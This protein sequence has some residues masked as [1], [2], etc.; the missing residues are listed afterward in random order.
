MVKPE[1]C[2]NIV[3]CDQLLMERAFAAGLDKGKTDRREVIKYGVGA[4]YLLQCASL[5]NT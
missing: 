5:I 3:L 2:R 4:L 1:V